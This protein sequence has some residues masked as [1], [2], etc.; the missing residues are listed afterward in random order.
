MVCPLQPN[1]LGTRTGNPLAFPVPAEKPDGKNTRRLV[2]RQID[3]EN[4]PNE[5]EFIE[6]VW[7]VGYKFREIN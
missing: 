6:T 3:I 2:D 5:P 4:D 7:G 1:C